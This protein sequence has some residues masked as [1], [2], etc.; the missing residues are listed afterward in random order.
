MSANQSINAL[1]KAYYCFN[2][3]YCVLGFGSIGLGIWL[4]QENFGDFVVAATSYSTIGI[5]IYTSVM[6]LTTIGLSL[7]AT[8]GLSA[9]SRL[10]LSLYFFIV[11][12]LVFIQLASCIASIIYEGPVRK[13]VKQALYAGINQTTVAKDYP[14]N[15]IAATWDEIQSSLGC[16]GVEN[17]RD[18][19]FTTRWNRNAFVPDSC[20]D[21]DQFSNHQLTINC[22]KNSRMRQ[23]FYQEG[24]HEPYT[25]WLLAHTRLIF[26][27]CVLFILVEAVLLALT[28]KMLIYLRDYVE[29]DYNENYNARYNSGTNAGSTNREAAVQLLQSPFEQYR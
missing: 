12:V 3:V 14:V 28:V 21:V 7:F 17:Y 19:F 10:Y 16:C 8:I 27:F 25:N 18:W 23:L 22:G 6:G 5:S 9:K 29:T 4:F 11:V 15:H 20:C 2:A 13:Q 26:V 24:C 1:K